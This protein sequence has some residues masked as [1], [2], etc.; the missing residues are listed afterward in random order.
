MIQKN[1]QHNQC[2]DIYQIYAKR[3]KTYIYLKC[4][5][6]TINTSA[7]YICTALYGLTAMSMSPMY[8]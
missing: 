5:I 1:L 4:T 7:P 2:N 8:V 6:K 3:T